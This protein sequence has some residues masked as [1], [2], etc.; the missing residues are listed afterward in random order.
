M[1][2]VVKKS[3]RMQVCVTPKEKRAILDFAARV[4]VP[5]SIWARTVI[6]REMK[7]ETE[8]EVK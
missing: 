6:L 5:F 2:W 4:G 1:S 7:R 3:V 8:S